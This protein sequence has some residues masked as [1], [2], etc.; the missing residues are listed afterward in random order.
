MKKYYIYRDGYRYDFM[1]Y[2][3]LAAFE[4]CREIGGDCVV[5]ASTGEVLAERG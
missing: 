1:F 3:I 5:D 4:M 2:N